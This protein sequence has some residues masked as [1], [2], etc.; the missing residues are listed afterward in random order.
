MGA[1]SQAGLAEEMCA[2]RTLF[3]DGTVGA[4]DNF[5]ALRNTCLGQGDR[6]VFV[7]EGL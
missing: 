3:C 4:L 6:H 2:G 7:A 5:G 1:A